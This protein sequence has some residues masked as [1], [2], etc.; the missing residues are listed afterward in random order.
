MLAA[1]VT[2][3]AA[4]RPNIVLIMSDDMGYSDLGCYGGEIHTPN[5]NKLAEGGLRFT[6]FYNTSR[7]CPTRASLI[8]GL[9]SHQ[10]GIGCMMEDRHLPGYKGDLSHNAVTIAE[11]MRGAGYAT[12]MAGK[13]HVTPYLPAEAHPDKNNWPMQRGFDRFYGTIHG[14]G[15]YYD[16]NSLVSGNEYVSPNADPNYTPSTFYYTDAITDHAVRFINEDSGDRPFFMYVAFTAAHWPMHALPEDIAKYKGR[17]DQGYEPIRR[18]RFERLKKMGIIDPNWKLSEQA[19]DWS[20]LE[21][22]AWEARCMEVY[23]AMV[24]RM[25]Q[26][27]GRIVEE[28]KKTGRL[29]HTLIFFLQ[30]KGGCAEGIGRTAHGPKWAGGDPDPADIKPMKATDLQTDMVPKATREGRRLRMGPDAMPGPADTYIAYGRDWANVSNTPFR[31]YKCYVHEGGISTPLIV[32]WPAYIRRH[33][34]VER[35]PGHLID[36]M[37]TCVDAAGAHYPEKFGG[38]D[39]LPMEGASL[40]PA[41]RGQP[42]NRTDA[43]YFEHLGSRAIRA[44]QWKL[45]AAGQNGKWEL[46]DM[47]ADRT[48]MNDL[49]DKK[50]EMAKRLAAQ[51]EAWAERAHVKPWPWNKKK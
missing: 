44:G 50:P 47:A 34:E 13:W 41:F 51:W 40:V 35:Q 27:V 28:L 38:H 12:Y 1:V 33:G 46:Y 15:S 9:Y 26:G 42:L 31:E 45:V 20:A 48:E 17:Y 18:A 6:Q 3:G 21:N 49:A 4:E 24:D 29:D 43:I 11:V 14:A 36:I 39:I 23:A 7:C 19:G 5:L 32:H 30:D 2:A 25:D 16:P 10:A 8:T 22:K 37:A